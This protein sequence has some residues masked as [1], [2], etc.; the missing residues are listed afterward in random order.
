MEH[1]NRLCK[2][3]ITGLG[4]NKSQRGITRAAE[5]LGTITPVLSNYDSDNKVA[6]VS[7]IH[8]APPQEKDVKKVVNQLLLS[9]VFSIKPHRKH[10]SFSKVRDVL[11]HEKHSDLAEWM[12]VRV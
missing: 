9:D 2:G 8:N 11:H 10:L 4:A 1:L 6:V 3:A 5:A 7:G 12:E